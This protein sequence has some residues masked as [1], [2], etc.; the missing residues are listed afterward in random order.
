MATKREKKLKER[1]IGFNTQNLAAVRLT[2]YNALFDPNMR[3]FFESKKVQQLLYNSGQIDKHGRVI[4]LEKNKNKLFIL[5]REFAQAEKVEERRQKEEMEMR[6]RVQRKRFNELEKIRKEEILQKLKIDRDLSK[7]IV[8]TMRSTK[9]G[10]PKGNN[11]KFNR[12]GSE[13]S[14]TMFRGSS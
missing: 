5:E 1:E 12:S 4:D 7:E 3:H 8:A 9:S 14:L 13:K 6:Y 2:E 10:A 11:E